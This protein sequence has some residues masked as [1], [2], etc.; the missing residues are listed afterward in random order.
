[1]SLTSDQPIM[2]E[3]LQRWQ[4]MMDAASAKASPGNLATSSPLAQQHPFQAP[5]SLAHLLP[6][7]LDL[8][9][10]G[11]AKS[12]AAAEPPK[13]KRGRPTAKKTPK[14]AE[15]P[16][17]EAP[18]DKAPR[19][20]THNVIERRYRNNLNARIA[21]LKKVVPSLNL[22]GAKQDVEDNNDLDNDSDEKPGRLNKGTI[23]AKATEY[24]HE[25]EAQVCAAADFR[26]R[27]VGRFGSEAEAIAKECFAV[28]EQPAAPAPAPPSK[29]QKVAAVAP[30]PPKPPQ[31]LPIS[32]ADIAGSLGT[33]LALMQQQQ[34]QI[35]QW[36]QIQ[37]Q[38]QVAAAVAAAASVEAFKSLSA[39]SPPSSAPSDAR[40]PTRSPTE[41]VTLS[42]VQMSPNS[43]VGLGFPMM[44][45]PQMDLLNQQPQMQ[46]QQQQYPGLIGLGT[47]MLLDNFSNNDALANNSMF[48]YLFDFDA[49]ASEVGSSKNAGMKF[50][51]VMFMSA[52]VLYAPSP[53]DVDGDASSLHDHVAGRILGRATESSGL[54]SKLFLRGVELSGALGVV[55]ASAWWMLKLGVL[56]FVV[57]QLLYAVH[58]AGFNKKTRKDEDSKTSADP[59]PLNQLKQLTAFTLFPTHVSENPE[60]GGVVVE[61]VR[62]VSCFVLGIGCAVE[63][64]VSVGRANQT[65]QWH[66]VVAK[67]SVRA[68]DALVESSCTSTL[69][70]L[71]ISLLA[72]SHASMA[73]PFISPIDLAKIKLSTALALRFSIHTITTETIYTRAITSLASYLFTDG[74]ACIQ[75]LLSNPSTATTTTNLPP[76]TFES[77]TSTNPSTNFWTLETVTQIFDQDDWI[78]ASSPTSPL[79]LLSRFSHTHLAPQITHTFH[80][81]TSS[82][83][84]TPAPATST[85]FTSTHELMHLYAQCDPDSPEAFAALSL[86]VMSCWTQGIE[87]PEAL[88]ALFVQS[89]KSRRETGVAGCAV[90]VSY[91]LRKGSGESREWGGVLERMVER[92]SRGTTGVDAC[93]EF[94]ALSWVVK[95][96]G[97][98]EGERVT[99][100]L[101]ARMRRVLPGVKRGG[102]SGEG[103]VGCV[104]GWMGAL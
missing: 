42:P 49:S 46:Q 25:L 35:Q 15:V 4:E 104:V 13:K 77:C 43:S 8:S 100:K 11:D 2:P 16:A 69:Q 23:L 14:A 31:P 45:P 101:V 48:D 44:M 40:S 6:A 68:L 98:E 39:T 52:S 94:A 89:V 64:L 70:I 82:L 75:D 20:V 96:L 33:G 95:G 7:E 99:G 60:M 38:Y 79:T 47:D 67:T 55:A 19:R 53:F 81:H 65:R 24:I 62:F 85:T 50:M 78:P 59:V 18:G 57:S 93:V 80:T 12:A 21:E 92:E 10:L 63:T 34:Q 84:A 54:D 28:V 76:W 51:A 71:N 17:E 83:L 1:M 32:P 73:G 90:W 3:M 9:F 22:A 5:P 37:Q 58:A 102:K 36:L 27:I 61:V 30:S 26:A 72:L 91:L 29:R 88:D 74:L 41:K 103:C 86:A 87:I 97:R 66:A 56:V